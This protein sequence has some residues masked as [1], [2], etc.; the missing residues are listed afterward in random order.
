MTDVAAAVSFDLVVRA[1]TNAFSDLKKKKNVIFSILHRRTVYI[2]INIWRGN[3]QTNRSNNY[4]AATEEYYY[5][6]L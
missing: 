5:E 3:D 1:A 2:F 6:I 4:C